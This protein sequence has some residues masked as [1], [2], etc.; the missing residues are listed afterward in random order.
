MKSILY[1]NSGLN[2]RYYKLEMFL[3]L[4]GEYIVEREYGNVAYR[5][6]TGVRKKIFFSIESAKEFYFKILKAKKAK[7]YS[8]DSHST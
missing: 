4:F 2:I 5:A 3:S 7:G 6:P 8:D 1:R